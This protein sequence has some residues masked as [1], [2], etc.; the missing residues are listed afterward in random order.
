MKKTRYGFMFTLLLALSLGAY[1]PEAAADP[2][3]ISMCQKIT[4]SGSYELARNLT[5]TGNC[6]VLAADYVTVD[7]G[8][9]TITGNGT[10]IGVSTDQLGSRRGYVVRHGMV[11]NFNRGVDLGNAVDAVIEGI[12]ASDSAE[13]GI[14]AGYSSIVTGN[15]VRGS[16]EVGIEA[17]DGS[18]V[19]G[20]TVNG[21]KKG[22]LNLGNGIVVNG[23][24]VV[25]GNTSD[26]NAGHGIHVTCPSN[27]MGNTVVQNTDGNI[28]IN[29][30]TPTGCSQSDNVAP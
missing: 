26:F 15:I 24:T 18:V 27:V 9:F 22:P 28:I 29:P 14:Y 1:L 30:A 20:N 6:I 25:S 2:A 16:G 11:A 17:L 4:R 12:Y 23:G 3:R 19:R 10:G 8:G 5:A 21:T 13:V 7:L